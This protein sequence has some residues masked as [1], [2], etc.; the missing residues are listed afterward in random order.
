M[1]KFGFWATI[2]TLVLSFIFFT[3]FGLYFIYQD[4]SVHNH[5]KQTYGNVISSDIVEKYTIPKG[6]CA[7]FKI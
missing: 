2:T 4:Y 3:G 7:N 5:Y 6:R 1:I